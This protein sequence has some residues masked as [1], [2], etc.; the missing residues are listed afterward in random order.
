MLLDLRAEVADPLPS[1]L[2]G[3]ITMVPYDKVT[4]LIV[5]PQHRL[6]RAMIGR[7]Y[8]KAT[9]QALASRLT[10]HFGVGA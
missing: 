6:V 10:A 3:V 4:L 5:L 1:I 8:S 7:L 9:A 2:G